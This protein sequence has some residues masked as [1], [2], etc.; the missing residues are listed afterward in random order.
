VMS[1]GTG[2]MHSEYNHEDEETN[3]FQIW[4]M[5]RSKGIEPRWD[6]AEFP[7]E[8]VTDR[9]PL[10]VSGDGEAPL[11]IHQDARIFAG[12][13]T[14]GTSLKHAVTGQAYL[15]VS[16]GEVTVNGTRAV[17][18]DG[19]AASG[20]KHLALDADGDAEILIIE[21]PGQRQAR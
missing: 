15:L 18:G 21:V 20:E 12:T 17:K 16:E 13:L 9:L 6:A 1:A 10:L 2:I 5:P 7:R 8:P 14:K 19:I 4:I 3:I 11:R